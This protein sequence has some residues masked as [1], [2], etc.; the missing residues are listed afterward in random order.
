MLLSVLNYF[1]LLA[2]WK[3]ERFSQEKGHFDAGKIA[4]GSGQI[5]NEFLHSLLLAI[6]ILYSSHRLRRV[7]TSSCRFPAGNMSHAHF[8]PTTADGISRQEAIMVE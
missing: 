1:H 4:C 3:N 6:E 7:S 8:A 2:I 5:T